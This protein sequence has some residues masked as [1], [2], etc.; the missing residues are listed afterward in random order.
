[1]GVVSHFWKNQS[2][3][4]SLLSLWYLPEGSA[5]ADRLGDRGALWRWRLLLTRMPCLVEDVMAALADLGLDEEDDVLFSSISLIWSSGL[6]DL[7]LGEIL[8]PSDTVTFKIVVIKYL[9]KIC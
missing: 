6:I 1:M 4:T 3:L 7:S 2:Y 5:V 9:F 8:Q